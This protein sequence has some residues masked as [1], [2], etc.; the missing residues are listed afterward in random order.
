MEI[1]D[2]WYLIVMFYSFAILF[3]SMTGLWGY[4][5]EAS[6]P[7]HGD[8][9][10]QRHWMEV[11]IKLPVG[12][13]YRNTTD[14]DLNY[15][16]LD[17]PPLTAYTSM[18]YGKVFEKAH[19]PLVEWET[20][21]GHESVQG[22]FLMRFSVIIFDCIIFIPAIL[23]T[24]CKILSLNTFQKPKLEKDEEKEKWGFT[25]FM[26]IL[27]L[28]LLLVLPSLILIDHG[29]F[30][31]NGVCIGLTL[32]ACNLILNDQLI[33]GSLFFCL[34][35]N[36]KQMALYYSLNFFCILLRKSLIEE[37]TVFG[38]FFKLFQIGM[39]VLLTFGVLWLPFCLFPAPN[40]ET[41]V[42]SL[43]HVLSRQFPFARG[44]FEDKVANLWYFLSRV[45]DI[46][47]L[48]PSHWLIRCST[49]L[50]LLLVLPVAINL[51]MKKITLA[52]FHLSLFVSA[53]AFFL[54]SFQVRKPFRQ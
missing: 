24:Y 5:G 28:I 50:T 11:T 51:L 48:L 39:T 31:Y 27:Q 30:Q 47:S 40:G 45:V 52:R 29:H 41:C 7:M 37:K 23:W 42:S 20:S 38:K 13:W 26:H 49:G 2:K 21:R 36:Y 3:R 17:Y 33:L 25:Y 22:K 12:D 53:L 6:P 44:I 34:S 35:L 14:N 18:I 16:G 43:L 4:S 54:A 46:R 32:L 9:E 8:F 1:P 15:W 10:A 19:P